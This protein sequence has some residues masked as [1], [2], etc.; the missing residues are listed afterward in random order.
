[1]FSLSRY[2]TLIPALNRVESRASTADPECMS[3]H[4][5]SNCLTRPCD[6]EVFRIHQ[7]F[8]TSGNFLCSA[9][10]QGTWRR[11]TMLPAT[12]VHEFP[13]YPAYKIRYPPPRVTRPSVV[14][15]SI[16]F[17]TVVVHR[18]TCSIRHMRILRVCLDPNPN[19]PVRLLYSFI[20]PSTSTQHLRSR[21]SV[22]A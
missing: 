3:P 12:S 10:P 2:F 22:S 11:P 4:T 8:N 21:L 18:K 19:L 15:R 7:G 16:S 14:S 9:C 5:G 6:D 1:M 17:S 20:S 13:Q